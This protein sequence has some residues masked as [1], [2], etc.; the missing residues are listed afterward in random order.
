MTKQVT[1]IKRSTSVADIAALLIRHRISAVPILTDDGQVMGI[2]SESDLIHRGESGTERKRKWWLELFAGA[3]GRA[4][5]YVKS[6]GLRAENIMSR[7]VIS[8]SEQ[9]DLADVADVL[10]TYRIRRVP[11]L[12]NGKLVG[13]IS[14][15]DLVRALAQVNVVARDV[16]RDDAALHKAIYDQIQSQRWLDA[17]YISFVVKEGVVDLWGFV[18]SD[19]QQHA[20]QVLVEGVPGVQKVGNNVRRLVAQES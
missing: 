8:V 5:D 19:E 6:H 12:R 13:I 14:R 17:V 15:S 16:T 2:V 7:V 18:G 3:D 11:V 9:A 10:D 4:R 20:L 1:T